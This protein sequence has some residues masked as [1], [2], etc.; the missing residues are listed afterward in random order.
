[1]LANCGHP[2]IELRRERHGNIMLKDLPEG[3]FRDCDEDEI[4]WAVSLMKR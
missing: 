3:E 1:M 4:D 2:V